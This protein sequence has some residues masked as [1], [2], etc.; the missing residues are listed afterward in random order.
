MVCSGDLD[1]G[2]SISAALPGRNEG[3][4]L[5]EDRGSFDLDS[6]PLFAASP[7][8]SPMPEILGQAEEEAVE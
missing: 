4:E 3:A 2:T 6:V 7:S 1:S 5:N 8:A